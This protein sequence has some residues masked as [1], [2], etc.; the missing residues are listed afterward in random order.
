MI[1]NRIV[2]GL[3]ILAGFSIIGLLIMGYVSDHWG[4]VGVAVVVITLFLTFVFLTV[5][6]I[7]AAFG[8]GMAHIFGKAIGVGPL[9]EVMRTM[10]AGYNADKRMTLLDDK[11]EQKLLGDNWSDQGIWSSTSIPGEFKPIDHEDDGF[12]VR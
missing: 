12:T 11:P 10:R 4:P 2:A 8:L 6:G 5:A 9:I 7:F 3:G 1:F